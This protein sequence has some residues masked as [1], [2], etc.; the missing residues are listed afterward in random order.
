MSSSSVFPFSPRNLPNV[1]IATAFNPAEHE[2]ERDNR[3]DDAPSSAEGD[4]WPYFRLTK[5]LKEDREVSARFKRA[6]GTTDQ[7]DAGI[8]TYFLDRGVMRTQA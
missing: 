8:A 1:V 4:K 3:Y 7:G 5:S 6:R 2:S